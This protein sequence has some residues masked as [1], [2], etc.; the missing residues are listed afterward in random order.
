MRADRD[1]RTFVRHIVV[2]IPALAGAAAVSDALAATGSIASTRLTLPGASLE[3]DRVLHQMAALHNDLGRRRPTPADVRATAGYLR[4]LVAHRQETG[5]DARL[6][7]AFRGLV[8][9]Q[10]RDALVGGAPDLATVRRGLARYGV[11]TAA[12]SL[13]LGAHSPEARGAVLD[14][15][16]RSGA[17]TYYMDPLVAF[18]AFSALLMET[19]DPDFCELLHEMI[20]LTEILTTLF[21]LGAQLLP[22]MVPECFASAVWLALLKAIE[23]IM[24]C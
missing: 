12:G 9:T 3:I 17:A 1:R 15:L 19:P 2:G 5:R 21:C 7:L 4:Q 10:G 24:Q 13:T 22:P 8:A 18:E 20:E 14:R 6:A 16:L 11:N 23:T